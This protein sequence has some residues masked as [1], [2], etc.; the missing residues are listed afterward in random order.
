M[1]TFANEILAYIL[2]IPLPFVTQWAIPGFNLCVQGKMGSKAS[3]CL[4]NKSGG[5]VITE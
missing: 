5:R 2:R 3:Y 1:Q 4:E